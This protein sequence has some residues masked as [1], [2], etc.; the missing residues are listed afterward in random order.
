MPPRLPLQRE[1]QLPHVARG[2]CDA[3][4]D[5][6]LPSV[7][8]VYPQGTRVERPLLPGR[9]MFH[10]V[11]RAER[12]EA[13]VQVER[14]SDPDPEGI[15]ERIP[16]TPLSTSGASRWLTRSQ[17]I[18]V[19]LFSDHQRCCSGKRHSVEITWCA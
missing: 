15:G 13:Q 1:V 6:T 8:L 5:F 12:S 9:Q 16:P 11:H 17:R 14:E 2:G 7:G 4:A 18:R 3:V 19:R 10:R